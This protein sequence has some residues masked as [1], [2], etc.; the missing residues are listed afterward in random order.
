MNQLESLIAEWKSM[1]LAKAHLEKVQTRIQTHRTRLDRLRFTLDKEYRDVERLEKRSLGGVFRLILG[2]DES[3]YE[4][5]KQE[6]LHAF[7][8]YKECKDVLELLQFEAGVLQQK[9]LRADDIKKALGTLLTEQTILIK[10]TY[11]ELF[12]EINAIHTTL[13]EQ[14]AYKRE[15]Y[16]AVLVAIRTKNELYE[17]SIDLKDARSG[18]QW[19]VFYHERKENRRQK[20]QRI[21]QAQRHAAK[22]K[23]LLAELEEELNDVYQY[24]KIRRYNT[25]DTFQHFN[26]IYYDSLISDWIVREK[27]EKSLHWVNGTMDAVV[28]VIHTLKA[29]QEVVQ[30]SVAYLKEKKGRTDSGIFAVGKRH[31]FALR[32]VPERVFP[33]H[34]FGMVPL[35]RC[36]WRGDKRRAFYLRGVN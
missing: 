27:I 30:K 8:Q 3:K 24:K 2:N 31:A 26:D 1:E 25:F 35:M 16:E 6:Y 4:L 33:M 13:N 36:F 34:I 9:L 32:D 29:Q 18:G 22:V 12:D 5:E 7:L 21:D 15:L 14:V 20:N 19:G 23:V 11:P 28:Q 17:M 10:Q